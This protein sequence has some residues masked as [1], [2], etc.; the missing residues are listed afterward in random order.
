MFYS[1]R[2]AHAPTSSAVARRVVERL[3]AQVD[4]GTLDNLRLLVSE[5]VSN[6]VEHVAGDDDIGLEVTLT[7]DRVRVEVSDAGPGFVHRP[8]KAGDPKG[9]G[10]GL[11]FVTML[12]DAWGSDADD[13]SRVWF[14]VP[15]RVHARRA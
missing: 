6:A 15:A 10:W 14:E 12:A 1:E 2:L 7:G 8:R 11:H 3:G 5:L 13:G 4:P 9:S